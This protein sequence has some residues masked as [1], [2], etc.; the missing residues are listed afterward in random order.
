MVGI[1]LCVSGCYLGHVAAGQARMLRARVPIDSMLTDEE[2]PKDVREKLRLVQSARG[3]A[4]ELGLDVG[5]QYTSYVPW[6]GDRV[7][8]IVVATRPG[9]VE[10]AGYTFPIVGTIPYKGFFAPEKAEAEAARQR[11]RGRDVCVVG[12]SAY[13]TL[14]W[15]DDPVTG[16]MLRRG[17]GS[18]VDTIVHELVHATV[19]VSDEARFNEGVANFIG[20]EASARF[21]AERGETERA[22]QRRATIAD[23]RRIG[24]ALAK[25]RSEIKALYESEDPGAQRDTARQVLNVRARESLAALPLETRD[26]ARVASQTRLNDACLALSGTYSDDLDDYAVLLSQSGGNLRAFVQRVLTAAKEEDPLD[27]I[28]SGQHN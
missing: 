27:A 26:P 19:Y 22:S 9:E 13:S 16:P 14:G 21:F 15:L 2:T 1:A 20:G 3:C 12:V 11:E 28:K 10:P 5:N 23:E 25:L 24:A 6:E 7:V 17:A 8:T 18:L 4:A